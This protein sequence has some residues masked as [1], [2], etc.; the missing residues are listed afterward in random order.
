VQPK[1][2]KESPLLESEIKFL[3]ESVKKQL[4]R[5]NTALIEVEAP[6]VICGDTHG[7]YRDLLRIFATAEWPPKTSYL[8]LGDYV[9]R[10]RRSVEVICLLF[11]LKLTF[12]KHIFLLR[13]NHEAKEINKFYGFYE[14][15]KLRYSEQLWLDFNEV[16]TW[17]PLVGLVGERLLCMHGGIP[18][19]QLESLDELKNLPMPI[20]SPRDNE[21]VADLLWSDPS[22]DVD[23][24]VNNP[25][26]LGHQFG[27]KQVVAFNKKFHLDLIVRAHQVFAEGYK[28][29]RNA[30]CIT[31]F[32][33]PNYG[34]EFNNDASALHVDENLQ[35]QIMTLHPFHKGKK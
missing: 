20:Q 12:P 29:M 35:C 2:L 14:E 28:W 8:F 31:V 27:A 5:S 24:F 26:G 23:S 9:D 16:F 11:A 13:G 15:V 30:P 33:A 7:Q 21:I 4:K 19:K 22:D 17:M 25:R 32:S 10:G 1:K 6:V 3:I 18:A 34:G